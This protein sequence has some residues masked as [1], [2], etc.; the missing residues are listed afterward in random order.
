MRRKIGVAALILAAMLPV[1]SPAAAHGVGERGDL[2]LELVWAL[3]GAA[4][5]VVF[6]FAALG[7]LWAH[8]SLAARST[9]S[10]PIS[11]SLST[12]GAWTIRLLGLA[13]TVLVLVV[14]LMGR[15]TSTSNIALVSIYVIFWV[16][17]PVLSAVFGDLW[18]VISPFETIARLTSKWLPEDDADED[19]LSWFAILPLAVFLWLELAYHDNAQPRIVGLL[20]FAYTIGI[21]MV[22]FARGAKTMRAVEG[23]G[24]FFS[25]IAL[26][27]PVGR[28]DDGRLGFRWPLAGATTLEQRRS[29]MVLLLVV[30]GGTTF[31]GF[32]RTQFWTDNFIGQKRDW[33]LTITQTLGLAFIIAV[34]VALYYLG[35]WL[36]GRIAKQ[37]TEEFAL[38][39]SHT[40]VPIALAYA[41]AHYFSLF[42]FEGQLF[43]KLLAD[44]FEEGWN[45]F[46]TADWTVDFTLVSTTVIGWV[47]VASIVIGHVIAVVLSHD[48]SL[49]RYSP[50]I[51]FRSH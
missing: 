7:V 48:R 23:F 24:V 2:P 51:A 13:M 43:L 22:L 10:H 18:R 16:G 37:R 44:P 47:Q 50:A 35:S 39:F 15:G 33:E 38:E 5:A 29:T 4:I 36:G 3:S 30:L 17:I 26:L 40:L 9:L 21:L 1:A 42:V 41:V 25:H 8:P 31:D 32:S 11:A 20:A 45:L 28:T 14:G 6:S 49:E 19:R 46:G 34:V 27:S 12:V